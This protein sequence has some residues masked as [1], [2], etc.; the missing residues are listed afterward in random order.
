MLHSSNHPGLI[1]PLPNPGGA[2]GGGKFGKTFGK[3]C[4]ARK[5]VVLEAPAPALAPASQGR[6]DA[7]SQ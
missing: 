4:C 3:T 1:K 7:A 5:N 2:A 6:L